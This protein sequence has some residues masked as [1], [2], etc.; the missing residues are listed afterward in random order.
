MGEPPVVR[1]PPDQLHS[2]PELTPVADPH[3]DDLLDQALKGTLPVY[4]AA[5]PLAAIVP[6][7]KNYLPNKHPAFEAG[8]VQ[9]MRQWQEGQFRQVCVYQAGQEFVLS[10]DYL[11][12]EAALRG[13]P[14]FVPCWVLGRP[15]HDGVCDVQGPLDIP[16]VK[17]VLGFADDPE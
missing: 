4:F 3:F 13:Q 7:D 15:E 12:Y 10:D 8:V 17:R 16:S 11:T 14:D 5:V 1:M 2:H 9:V 6:F